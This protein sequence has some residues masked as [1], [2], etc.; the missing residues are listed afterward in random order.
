MVRA[1]ILRHRVTFYDT[2]EGT[3]EWGQPVEGVQAVIVNEPAEVRDIRGREYW[4]QQQVPAGEVTTRIRVRYRPEYHRQMVV[5]W[6]VEGATPRWFEVEAVLDPDGR[7]R[8]LHIMCREA[9]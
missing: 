4:Q 6:H 2:V 8:D 7:R 9:S 3:D 5:E 1:G